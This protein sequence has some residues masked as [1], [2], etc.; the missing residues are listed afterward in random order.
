MV[1]GL[2]DRAITPK[3]GVTRKRLV[4]ERCFKIKLSVNSFLT[5]IGGEIE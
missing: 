2:A 3:K 5:K 1:T 4:I